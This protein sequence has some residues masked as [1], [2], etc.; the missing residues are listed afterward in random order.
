MK[1]GVWE[2][3]G[4]RRGWGKGTCPLCRDNEDARHILTVKL[5]RNKKMENAIYE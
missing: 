3:R 4:I 1:A 5:P 2:L